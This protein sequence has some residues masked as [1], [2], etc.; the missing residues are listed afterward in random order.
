MQRVEKKEWE[1][2]AGEKQSGGGDFPNYLV[3]LQE[4]QIYPHHRTF[5]QPLL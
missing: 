1:E 2:D 4:L 3:V 5:L